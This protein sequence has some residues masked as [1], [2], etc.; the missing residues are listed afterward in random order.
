MTVKPKIWL[1]PP[2]MGG[3]EQ[4]FINDAFK[5]N[6]IAPVGH[7][8]TGF[9]TDLETYL[10][11][12]SYAIAL[13]S[14][15]AAIHLALVLLNVGKGDEVIC[16]TKT[17]VAS[18]NPVIYQGAT[19]VF[20][21]SETD[22]WNMCPI[23]L[24]H[25]IKDRINKGKKPKAIIVINLYGM[26]YKVNEIHNIAKR[27]EI[28]VL[29]DSAEALGS[30]YH[31]KPC[32]TFGD[33]AVLS[34]NGNKI[35]T[36]SGGG[37]LI[38]RSQQEKNK[39]IYLATQ[40]KDNSVEYNHTAIGYNYR[41]P[42]V[43]AGIGRGQMQVLEKHIE[44]RRRNFNYYFKELNALPEI[45]FLQEP[46]G[47]SSNRW[48]T[49]VVFENQKQRDDIMKLLESNNIE[50]RPSWKPMHLQPVYKGQD[51]YLNGT[52]EDLYSKGLCLPSGS[53]L[54]IE[55]L[56]RITNLIKSYFGK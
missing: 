12:N 27:Y 40:A 10:S 39:G 4:D 32:G 2:H 48:L 16:Q 49:C 38:A 44:L 36:T 21:D 11:N 46:E 30:H 28:P 55:D 3:S 6:F 54:T 31:G 23:L 14:G 26:P 7:N 8:I 13:T 42:N 41:M 47:F 15:T 45:S 56:E 9:E 37:A 53:S 50:S 34:F 5:T 1:S 24:E 43:T 29:E 22:T 20:V 18:V 52:S 19:P 33:Y 25:A 51:A 17:F 35:I